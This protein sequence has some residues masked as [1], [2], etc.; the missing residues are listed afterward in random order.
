[1]NLLIDIGNTQI[2]IGLFKGMDLQN[3]WRI[4]SDIKRTEDEYMV[5]LHHFLKQLELDPDSIEGIAL[6]SVVPNQTAIFEKL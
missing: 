3:S 6:A 1:M 5:S 2:E 4:S